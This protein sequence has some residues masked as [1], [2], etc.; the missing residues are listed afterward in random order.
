MLACTKQSFTVVSCLLKAGA[1]PLLRNKDGWNSFHIACREGH[2]DI[3]Q[4]LNAHSPLVSCTKSNNLR[5]PLHSS[6]LHGHP[7]VVRW[8]LDSCDCDPSVQ[9]SCGVTP[10]MDALRAG[11]VDTAKVLMDAF[12]LKVSS[13]LA[14]EDKMGRQ[15]IHHA[16]QSGQLAAL[17]FL[18]NECKISPCVQSKFSG[19]T[20]LHTAAQ[21]GQTEVLTSLLSF[22]A[23]VNA[24]DRRGRSA[25]H[26]ASGGQHLECAKTLLLHGALPLTD[27]GGL[28]PQQ[29]AR[30]SEVVQIF[31]EHALLE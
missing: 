15:A 12:E 23:D 14:T 16:A 5:T 30:K 9:D 29:L 17:Y 20:P 22:G 19:E 8:L 26:K 11:Y 28:T 27:M 24:Q 2:L 10:L 21:E 31:K 4:S 7:E 13:L 25:L 3:I 6:A 18:I 1:D